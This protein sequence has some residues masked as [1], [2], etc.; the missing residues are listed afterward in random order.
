MEFVLYPVCHFQ[1]VISRLER[2][3]G[4]IYRVQQETILKQKIRT[5]RMA[6]LRRSRSGFLQHRRTACYSCNGQASMPTCFNSSRKRKHKAGAHLLKGSPLDLLSTRFERPFSHTNHR[7][8]CTPHA[9]IRRGPLR[10]AH[11]ALCLTA[12]GQRCCT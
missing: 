1:A 10:N 6:T 3:T 4:I 7:A 5:I 2:L 8:F 12:I 11:G 9:T